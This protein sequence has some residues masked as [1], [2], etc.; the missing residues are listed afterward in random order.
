MPSSCHRWW[1]RLYLW[2]PEPV[3]LGSWKLTEEVTIGEDK[4][5]HF[6]GV[7][8]G[9]A[10][11]IIL[12]A[13]TQQIL[14]GTERS[15]H[16]VLGVLAQTMKDSATV[17]GESCSELL[18]AHAVTQL[19]SKTPGKE[20]VAVGSYAKALRML[21]TKI[22]A[23]EGYDS[24]ALVALFWA[25]HSEGNSPAG[26]DVKEGSIDDMEILGITESF[27]MKRQV[28]LST[29]GAAEAILHVDNIIKAAPWKRVL[30]TTPVKHFCMLLCTGPVHS[31]AVWKT[32][33]S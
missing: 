31:N 13:I 29:A 9:E 20:P 8:L 33:N 26:L 15:L 25:A 7:A 30:I 5:L 23:N 28:L 17:Y 11:T 14:Y 2:H 19:A 32:L 6:S 21:L 27:Q 18:M 4:H 12:H 3:K 22:A 10:Y 24:A 16:D 1:N